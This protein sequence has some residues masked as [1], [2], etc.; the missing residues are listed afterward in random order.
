[1]A[2]AM[3]RCLRK[4][5]PLSQIDMVTRADFLDLISHN[6]HLDRK[7]GLPRNQGLGGLQRLYRDIQSQRY[8][9]IYDAH[10][11][12]RSTLLMPLLHAEKK[13]FFNKR[14]LRRD[15]ALTF[16]LPLMQGWPRTLER[17]LE[18]LA[19]LGVTY[20]GKG[21]EIFVAPE[22]H[23]SVSQKLPR[24]SSSQG[25]AWVGL[26]PSAQWPGKR[27]PLDRFRKVMEG[28]IEK[29]PHRLIVL[30]GKEDTFCESLSQG[31]PPERVVNAQGKLSI[32]ES[33]AALSRCA[34]VIANDTGMMH[35]ADAL[36]VPSVLMLG[37]TSRE[38]GCLP[39]HPLSEILEHNLWCRPCS[40]NGQ[41]PCLRRQ[42]VCLENTT[43]EMVLNASLRLSQRLNLP[44]LRPVEIP[45]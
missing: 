37:P 19:P 4:A 11:S 43:V 29:T 44:L 7:V 28:L 10:R 42:R 22:S 30:G 45:Q 15:L 39:F 27:W 13:V 32:A 23:Q 2:T 34:F 16:K 25:Q 12:L 36:A 21:P 31:L 14:Y 9:L 17:Y 35:V 6:P 40:K 3:I 38:L 24:F 18:P 1:M 5:F 33:A 20:D 41:A 8:D 26:I